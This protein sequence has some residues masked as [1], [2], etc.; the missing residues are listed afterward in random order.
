[1][2]NSKN[3][4]MSFSGLKTSALY[5]LRDNK[6]VMLN[7]AEQTKSNHSPKTKK[8][9]NSVKS[10]TQD[11]GSVTLVDFCASFEQAIVDLLVSKTLKAI[12]KYTPR[13]V[14]LSGGVSA[15]EK[16]RKTLKQ[17]INK[18]IPSS[19]FYYPLPDYCMDNGTMIA[20]TGYYQAKNKNF[21]KWN[22]IKANPNWEIYQ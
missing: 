3:F 7:G 21:T 17:K 9:F 18:Q 8:F 16:L 19:T 2:I 11:D 5:W 4:D 12:K 1:M 6:L 15:N 20:I 10:L 22:K 14:I 13:T